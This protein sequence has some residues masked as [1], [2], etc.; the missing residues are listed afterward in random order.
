MRID[1]DC[2]AEADIAWI[3]VEGYDPSTAVAE[4]TDAGLGE[5]DPSTGQIMGL[6]LYALTA[7][8]FQVRVQDP[9]R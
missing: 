4:Q 8:L 6:E 2:D 7:P 3:R 9:P 5:L 1:R